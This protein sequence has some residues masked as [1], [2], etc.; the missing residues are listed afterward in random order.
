MSETESTVPAGQYFIVQNGQICT[1][2][3]SEDGKSG[4]W[5][6]LTSDP[7]LVLKILQLERHQVSEAINDLLG[8]MKQL[9]GGEPL[10]GPKLAEQ[11]AQE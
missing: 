10:T 7:Y 3:P 2:I 5:A 1:W 11:G 6:P 4:A 9:E 8:A